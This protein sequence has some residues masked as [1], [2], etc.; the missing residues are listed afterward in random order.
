MSGFTGREGTG[1]TYFLNPFNST[2][3]LVV[4]VRASARRFPSRDQAKDATGDR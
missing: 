1:F 3:S 4:V 2:M